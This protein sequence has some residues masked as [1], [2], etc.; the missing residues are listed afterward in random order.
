M[1]FDFMFWKKSAQADYVYIYVYVILPA[2]SA[3]V[4][5]TVGADIH[6]W[7]IEFLPTAMIHFLVQN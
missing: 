2:F 3:S 4:Y 6:S 7:M 1:W 5:E